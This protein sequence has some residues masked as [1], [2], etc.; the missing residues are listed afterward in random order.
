V[1]ARQALVLLAAGLVAG[2]T[3]TD[4]LERRGASLSLTP[5]SEV[6]RQLVGRWGEECKVVISG[7]GVDGRV[8]GW[9]VDGEAISGRFREGRDAS[10]AAGTLTFKWPVALMSVPSGVDGSSVRVAGG[11]LVYTF[12]PATARLRLTGP[13]PRWTNSGAPASQRFDLERCADANPAPYEWAPI[14]AL[15]PP[16]RA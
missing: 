13:A 10:G 7:V 16:S 14:G 4:S 15:S 8:V 9:G 12:Y 5:P 11:D 6:A 1:R 2:C 3:S